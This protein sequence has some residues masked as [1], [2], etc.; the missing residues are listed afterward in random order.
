MRK[1]FRKKVLPKRKRRNVRK[2]GGYKSKSFAKAV[3]RIVHKDVESKSA[4][5]Q[6]YSIN[7]NSGI[8][9]SGDAL[10]ILPNIAQGTADNARIGDQVRAQ[11]LRVKG[12]VTSN[13]TYQSYSNCRLGIRVMIVQ[14]KMYQDYATIIAQAAV[15][16]GTLLKK[17]G[18]TT[19]FTGIVPDLMAD[20]NTDAITKYYD[21][22][23]YVNTPY[24][25]TSVG[26]LATYNSVKFFSKTL[27]LRNKLLRYDSSINSGLTPVGYNPV[28]LVGYVHLDGS[29]PDTI[30][31]QVTM[32]CDSY[33][34]YEDA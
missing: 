6:Q 34:D 17:G 13:L 1:I 33:L 30:T 25:A 16:M 18:T 29:S 28:M 12:F 23:F 22:V 32:S 11:K 8:N 9:S 26:D 20:I 7:F 4:Y 2:A 10:Q 21:K 31:T 5:N 15:W 27:N 3:Q 19:G 24:V 14:P